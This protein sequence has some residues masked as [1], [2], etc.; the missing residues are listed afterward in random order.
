MTYAIFLYGEFFCDMFTDTE[1]DAKERLKTMY[2]VLSSN[3]GHFD[4]S[5]LE[6]VLQ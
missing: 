5:K 2:K 4:K 6:M 1:K 3:F